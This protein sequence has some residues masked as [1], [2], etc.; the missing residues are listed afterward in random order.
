M[1]LRMVKMNQ[2]EEEYLYVSTPYIGEPPRYNLEKAIHST[3]DFAVCIGKMSLG[4]WRGTEGYLV[5]NKRTG[6]V[7]GEISVEFSAIKTIKDLQTELD[8]VL[9]GTKAAKQEEL[10]FPE[11]LDR[12]KLKHVN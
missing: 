3:N 4:D 1:T 10:S 5:V 11:M 9:E 8:A 12:L 6:V 7:E 2:S